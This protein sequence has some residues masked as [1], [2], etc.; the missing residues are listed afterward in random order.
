M[1]IPGLTTTPSASGFD[2]T[3]RK[4][5]AEITARGLTIFGR[6][7]HAAGASQ[8]GLSLRPTVLIIF[9]NAKGGTP[10]MQQAQT[11]SI[12]LPLKFLVWEDETSVIQISYNQPAWL[13]ERHGIGHAPAA[14]AMQAALESITSAVAAAKA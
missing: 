11:I 6:I 5:E 10:L 7:N 12:D 3:V 1:T 13:A 8:V 9:G 2:E 4:L 14:Q